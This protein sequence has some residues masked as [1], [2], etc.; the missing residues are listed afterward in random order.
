[1]ITSNVLNV[2]LWIT[3]LKVNIVV[4]QDNTMINKVILVN[5][6]FKQTTVIKELKLTINFNVKN[7][8]KI[9]LFLIIKNVAAM[10]LF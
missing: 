9:S 7:V 6:S 10:N 1:M 4:L 2:Y 3:T 5:K 8:N